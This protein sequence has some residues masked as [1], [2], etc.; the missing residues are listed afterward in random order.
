MG[1]RAIRPL[2]AAALTIA[3]LAAAPA[4]AADQEPL[5]LP[6]ALAAGISYDDAI[7]RLLAEFGPVAEQ[8]YMTDS[9]L[10]PSEAETPLLMIRMEAPPGHDWGATFLFCRDRLMAYSTPVDQERVAGLLANL[11]PRP[12]LVLDDRLDVYVE[13]LDLRVLYQLDADGRYRITVTQPNMLFVTFDFYGTCV[14]GSG[15]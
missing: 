4:R 2:A 9:V 5:N 14:E 10:E 8:H 13:P 3:T 15:G 7:D 11:E 12:S 6:E 1:L